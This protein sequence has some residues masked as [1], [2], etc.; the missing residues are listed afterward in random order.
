MSALCPRLQAWEG[1]QQFNTARWRYN[2][3]NFLK[4][5][6]K[7]HPIARPLGRGIGVWFV[8]LAS[9]CDILQ[10]FMQYVTILDRIITT[11]DYIT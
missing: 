7:P 3:V 6:H 5:I 10:L 8:D 11:L 2:A 4:N 9:D 1:K